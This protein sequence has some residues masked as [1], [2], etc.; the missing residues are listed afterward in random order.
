MKAA[1]DEELI[2]AI[3]LCNDKLQ[4]EKIRW[5]DPV[6]MHITLNFF[7]DTD[8]AQLEMLRKGIGELAGRHHPDLIRF[9]GSGV[10]PGLRRPKVI[11]IGT[12]GHDELDLIKNEVDELAGRL[13][14]PTDDRPF[15]PHLTLGRIKY[16]KNAQKLQ[17][18][19]LQT[20]DVIFQETMINELCFTESVLTPDGPEYTILQKYRLE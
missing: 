13:G 15:S 2:K 6:K 17:E 7:G 18:W 3:R 8:E 1:P 5:V 4:G 20:R 19:L 16:L 11:W 12:E 10:F 14:F 9:K